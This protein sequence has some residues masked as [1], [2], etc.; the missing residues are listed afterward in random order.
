M[1]RTLLITGG[2]RGI[3]AAI[4]ERFGREGHEVLT[5]SREDLD[6]A[7][8]ESLEAFISRH[9]SRPVDILINNAGINT[10]GLIGALDAATW[11]AMLQVNLTSP[12]RLTQAVLPGMKER[13]WG[14]VLNVSSIFS[15]VTKEKRA[16]YSMTKAGLNA[17]TRSVTV[18]YGPFGILANTLCPGYVETAM[19]RQNNTPREIEAINATIP[20]RRPAQPEEIARI[21]YFLCSEDNTYITGREIVADGGFTC[22]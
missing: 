16:A 9:R 18:E 22:Q 10:L 17:F 4:A 2:S 15:L 8:P 7:R 1:K 19:T 20:L 14:R 3:G 12:V 6:L 13:G 11:Q 21:A 5:P